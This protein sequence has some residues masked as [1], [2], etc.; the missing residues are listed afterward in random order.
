MKT[1]INSSLMRWD[2]GYRVDA[3]KFPIQVLSIFAGWLTMYVVW[4]CCEEKRLFD[5]SLV[6]FDF[7]QWLVVFFLVVV[8]SR[9]LNQS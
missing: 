8:N 3:L 9:G 7:L 4:H 5:C 2:L 1:K 6:P